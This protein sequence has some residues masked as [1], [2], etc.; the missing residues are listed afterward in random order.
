MDAK[1][2]TALFQI[3]KLTD[4]ALG[5]LLDC[6][7]NIDCEQLS[8]YPK[9]PLIYNSGVRYF[10]DGNDDP[11]MDVLSILSAHRAALADNSRAIVDCEDLACWR[12]AELRVRFGVDANPTWIRRMRSDG[13][14]LIHIF[15]RLPNGSFEDPSRIMGMGKVDGL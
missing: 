7:T 11:W 5:Y 2:Y 1:R 4:G 6:L 14:Q 8:T 12:A 15:V 3:A 13:K 9:I 10:H